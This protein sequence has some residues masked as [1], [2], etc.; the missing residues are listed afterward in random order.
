MY[1]PKPKIFFS[2]IVM[3]KVYIYAVYRLRLCNTLIMSDN[4]GKLLSVTAV[5]F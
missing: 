1:N 3:K 2:C 4:G 5:S